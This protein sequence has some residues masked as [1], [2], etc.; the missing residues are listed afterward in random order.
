MSPDTTFPTASRR[1]HAHLPPRP[2]SPASAPN[3]PGVLQSSA[4]YRCFENSSSSTL[5]NF[6]TPFSV[7]IFSSLCMGTTVPTFPSGV[8]FDNLTWLPVLPLISNPILLQR[9]LITFSPE[10]F[11][12]FGTDCHLKCCHQRFSLFL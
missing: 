9:I 1:L 10:T 3:N 6:R 11:L 8:V 2:P 5:A 12:S 4:R 7:P